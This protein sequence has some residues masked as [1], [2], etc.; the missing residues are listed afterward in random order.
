[1]LK[2]KWGES[3][4]KKLNAPC[5]VLKAILAQTSAVVA[6]FCSLDEKSVMGYNLTSAF[7]S[8]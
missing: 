1:L 4:S 3:Y 2:K 6:A 7:L 5:A 8:A